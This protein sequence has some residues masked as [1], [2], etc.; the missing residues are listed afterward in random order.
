M[1]QPDDGNFLEGN[2]VLLTCVAFGAPGNPNITWWRNGV[3]LYS[4]EG[5]GDGSDSGGEGRVRVYSQ[6]ID[7]DGME[8][9][10]S[11]L[12]LCAITPEEAGLYSCSAH[13]QSGSNAT[14]D[15]F[16]VN[17]TITG[18]KLPGFCWKSVLFSVEQC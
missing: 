7:I 17:V 12:E 2:T 3:E 14:S 13:L 8:F 15:D 18:R 4:D 6:I 11:Y 1:I 9:V 16:F 10:L 5:S